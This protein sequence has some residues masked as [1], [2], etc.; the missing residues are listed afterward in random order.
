MQQISGYLSLAFAV[1]SVVLVC[2]WS[3]NKMSR[4]EEVYQLAALTNSTVDDIYG[5]GYLQGVDWQEH[6]FSWH[7]I[8]MTVGLVFCSTAALLSF[9]IFPFGHTINK[10]LHVTFHSAAIICLSIGM[11]A[12]FINHNSPNH[13]PQGSMSPNLASAHTFLGL[14]AVMAYLQN[15]LG[16]FIAFML[17]WIPLDCICLITCTSAC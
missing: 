17:P 8:M 6:T 11:Y 9:R 12:I 15:Y 14:A 2:A 13:N 7:P 3:A 5:Y 10:I 4:D 16:G 1:A